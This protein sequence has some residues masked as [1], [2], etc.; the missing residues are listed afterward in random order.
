MI[1]AFDD[2][3]SAH[4]SAVVVLLCGRLRDQTPVDLADAATTLPSSAELRSLAL[5]GPTDIMW[6]WSSG[7]ADLYLGSTCNLHSWTATY[8]RGRADTDLAAARL[9][10]ASVTF[11]GPLDRA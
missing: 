8:W 4:P 11:S 3:V 10:V 9:L 2:G 5:A 7:G 1:G 6:H